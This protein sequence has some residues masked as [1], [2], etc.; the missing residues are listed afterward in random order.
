M[1]QGKGS[2]HSFF[3]A[4]G[5]YLAGHDLIPYLHYCVDRLLEKFK[6][7]NLYYRLSELRSR[8]DIIKKIITSMDYNMYVPDISSNGWR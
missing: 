5:T 7:F 2:E 1:A 4:S 6:I 3:I 8:D